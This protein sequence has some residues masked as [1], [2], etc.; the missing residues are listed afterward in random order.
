M[1]VNRLAGRL[2]AIRLLQLARHKHKHKPY[3]PP[4]F[5][6]FPRRLRGLGDLGALFEGQKRLQPP[7]R[8]HGLVSAQDPPP[9]VGFPELYRVPVRVGGRRTQL[10]AQKA[11]QSLRG[12]VHRNIR[13]RQQR[14]EH[15]NGPNPR[16]RLDAV[17]IGL[18]KCIS[19]EVAPGVVFNNFCHI[20]WPP[21]RISTKTLF[22]VCRLLPIPQETRAS[23][24][25]LKGGGA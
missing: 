20:W 6:I 24:R 1:C 23:L 9:T 22:S 18:F 5:P 2:A 25:E 14:A 10:R 19:N 11:A 7:L 12:L 16:G 13:Q 8:W 21:I 3:F 17:R 15:V 4:Y